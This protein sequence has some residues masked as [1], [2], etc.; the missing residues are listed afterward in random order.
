MT[1]LIVLNFIALV[2]FLYRVHM[3]LTNSVR[4]LKQDK[5]KS[6]NKKLNSAALKVRN[7]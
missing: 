5:E 7:K 3:S 4:P 6:F 2:Y 1:F